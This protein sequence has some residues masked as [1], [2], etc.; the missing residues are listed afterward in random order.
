[1]TTYPRALLAAPL[2]AASCCLAGAY[3]AARWAAE[4]VIGAGGAR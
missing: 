3:M 2:L 4:T 1:V